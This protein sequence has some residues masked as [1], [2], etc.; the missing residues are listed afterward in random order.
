MATRVGFVFSNL[1]LLRFMTLASSKLWPRRRGN[2]GAAG[3]SSA[4]VHCR[5]AHG[6]LK[7]KEMEYNKSVFAQSIHNKPTVMSERL[8]LL[9]PPARAHGTGALVCT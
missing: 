4:F 3:S 8:L 5:T 7:K 9:E 1:H 6:D 2:G